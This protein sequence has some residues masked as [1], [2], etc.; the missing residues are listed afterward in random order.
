MVLGLFLGEY[1]KHSAAAAG[2]LVLAGLLAASALD[3]A[4]L[5]LAG[6]FRRLL[7]LPSEHQTTGNVS[8]TGGTAARHYSSDGKRCR[9]VGLVTGLT[10]A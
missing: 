8:G 7:L 6:A 2:F 10:P 3:E 9:P 5:A 1:S 4:G